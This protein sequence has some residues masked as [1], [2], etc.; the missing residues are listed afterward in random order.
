MPEMDPHPS[1]AAPVHPQLETPGSLLVL[2]G[3]PSSDRQHCSGQ[4]LKGLIS[5][6]LAI[7]FKARVSCMGVEIKSPKIKIG[8]VR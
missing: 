8:L 2:Q 1:G 4:L 5:L 3:T 6:S 7:L